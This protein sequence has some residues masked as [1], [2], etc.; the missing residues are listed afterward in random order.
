MLVQLVAWM[1]DPRLTARVQH[2]QKGRE[3]RTTRKH[4]K[5]SVLTGKRAAVTL[6]VV[7]T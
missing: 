5:G 3:L 2:A 4:W 6:L 1:A 7:G